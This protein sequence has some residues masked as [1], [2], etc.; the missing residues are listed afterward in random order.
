MNILVVDDNKTVQEK[1]VTIITAQGHCVSSSVNGLDALGKTQSTN[2]D[3][4]V[5]DHLMPLMNGIKLVKNLKANRS[6]SDI[7][8]I[9]MTTQG[10]SA[11]KNLSEFPLFNAVIEKPINENELIN[12]L[13]DFENNNFQNVAINNSALNTNLLY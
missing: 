3:V 12:L 5:I 7:P 13:S 11:I 2:Y 10:V 1:L 4:Y 8:I 9:F 6:T